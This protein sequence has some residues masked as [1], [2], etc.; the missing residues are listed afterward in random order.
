MTQY[1]SLN[2][3]YD[4]HSDPKLPPTTPRPTRGKGFYFKL[5]A[6][7]VALNI[8]VWFLWTRDHAAYDSGKALRLLPTIATEKI[9]S[10]TSAPP[11][12]LNP[13]SASGNPTAPVVQ[14]AA[15]TPARAVAALPTLET[16]TCYVW[17]FNSDNDLKRATS[18][19]AGHGWSDF[20]S[21]LVTVP[22]TY[23]VFLGAFLTRSEIDSAIKRLNQLNI[24]AYNLLPSNEISLSVVDT[25]EAAAT[26]KQKLI[27]RGLQGVNT[28]ERQSNKQRMRYRFDALTPSSVA[29]LAELSRTAGM[30]RRCQ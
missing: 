29:A 24:T 25:A 8:A 10:P 20:S 21:E 19:L 26:F 2:A 15:L 16:K 5:A 28:R 4:S 1:D 23:M 17:T 30:L 6:L 11:L 7:L 13:P 18:L 12:N 3:A 22:T 27:Q 14:P 9:V